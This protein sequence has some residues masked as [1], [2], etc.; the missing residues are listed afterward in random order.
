MHHHHSFAADI[1]E[2]ETHMTMQADLPGVAKNSIQLEVLGD[3]LTV[4]ASSAISPK[5]GETMRHQEFEA[6]EFLRRFPLSK[7]VDQSKIEAKFDDGVLT[8]SIAK[9]PESQPHVVPVH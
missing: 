5:E 1:F 2:T 8:V 3:V 6:Q 9:F 7:R 4:K